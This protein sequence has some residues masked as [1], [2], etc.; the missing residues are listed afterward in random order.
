MLSFL[1]LLCGQ[2]PQIWQNVLTCAK[3]RLKILSGSKVTV[4]GGVVVMEHPVVLTALCK[5]VGKE[6]GGCS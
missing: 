4:G 6:W 1:F 3:A 5:Y 2:N